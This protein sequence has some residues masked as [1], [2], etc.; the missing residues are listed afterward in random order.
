MKQLVGIAL[1]VALT[2]AV[3]PTLACGDVKLP[4]RYPWVISVGA[5]TSPTPPAGRGG[6]PPGQVKQVERID[7]DDA[8]GLLSSPDDDVDDSV[9]TVPIHGLK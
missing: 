2:L 4:A 7:E 5:T 6:T 8:P 1:A 3:M 9:I